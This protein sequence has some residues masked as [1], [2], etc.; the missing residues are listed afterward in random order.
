MIKKDIIATEP[1]GPKHRCYSNQK[2]LFMCSSFVGFP[3]PHNMINTI[4]S[5]YM[6]GKENDSPYIPS[7]VTIKEKMLKTALQTSIPPSFC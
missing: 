5:I 7:K 3:S 1:Y 6:E 4:W 2:F